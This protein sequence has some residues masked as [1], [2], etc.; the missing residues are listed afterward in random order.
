MRKYRKVPFTPQEDALIRKLHGQ[1]G[2]QQKIQMTT[3]VWRY[4]GALEQRAKC[5]GFG[6]QFHGVT[7]PTC[8][9]EELEQVYRLADTERGRTTEEIAE[10]V[11]RPVKIVEN[12]LR[13]LVEGKLIVFKNGV[14]CANNV[15][16]NNGWSTEKGRAFTNIAGRSVKRH[17]GYFTCSESAV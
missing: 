13:Y 2:W 14:W 10:M 11:G 16:V 17:N 5:L 9:D 4:H 6:S 1:P 8:S 7:T 15:Q 12:E 3:G